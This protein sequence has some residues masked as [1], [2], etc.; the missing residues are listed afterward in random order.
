[1]LAPIQ[2]LTTDR[3]VSHLRQGWLEGRS[4]CPLSV[5]KQNRRIDV[6]NVIP[7]RDAAS[8]QGFSRDVQEAIEAEPRP[9]PI[10]RRCDHRQGTSSKLDLQRHSG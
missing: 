2:K 6:L 8:R 10:Y 1:M 5:E 3:V 4:L 9:P 7:L